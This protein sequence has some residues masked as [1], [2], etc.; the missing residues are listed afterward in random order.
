[1]GKTLL[2][3]LREARTAIRNTN[4]KKKGRN[5]YSGYD[6]FTPEQV[7]LL[8]SNVCEELGMLPLY[9]LEADEFGLKQTML[10]IN[11]DDTSDMLSFEL[12][13]KHG[14]IKATNETQQMGGTDTYSER[15]LKMKVF[16]IEDNNLDPDSKDHRQRSSQSSSRGDSSPKKIYSIGAEKYVRKTGNKNG[17]QWVGYFPENEELEPIWGDDEFRLT[18][19]NSDLQQKAED[20]NKSL[21]QDFLNSTYN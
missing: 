7:G 13:T 6:Y 10:L 21:D 4:I 15:Y 12:R 20:T 18:K 16:Q 2:E 9:N 19:N 14:E 11:M 1:M 5:E 17:K 8:V 3:K